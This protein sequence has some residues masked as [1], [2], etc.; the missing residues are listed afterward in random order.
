MSGRWA[1]QAG[2][3]TPAERCSRSRAHGGHAAGWRACWPV[4]PSL[5]RHP[6]ERRSQRLSP[7]R[8]G[9]RV[10]CGGSRLGESQR[11]KSQGSRW[12]G[13]RTRVGAVIR[14][15]AESVRPAAVCWSHEPGVVQTLAGHPSQ[16]LGVRFSVPGTVTQL[17]A[18]RCAVSQQ[19]TR[20][21]SLRCSH[22]GAVALILAA[23]ACGRLKKFKSVVYT[24]GFSECGRD[25]PRFGCTAASQKLQKLRCNSIINALNVLESKPYNIS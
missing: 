19:S 7:R 12:A 4:G 6:A 1:Q 17:M 24:I 2:C 5:L 8:T 16:P 23:G 9:D 18:S 3:N 13:E 22:H 10:A 14:V 11:S 20:G 25:R 15:W 21:R